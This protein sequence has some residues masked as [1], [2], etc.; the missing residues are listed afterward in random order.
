MINIENLNLGLA[1][2]NQIDWYCDKYRT[3]G[4]SQLT[5]I[6]HLWADNAPIQNWDGSPIGV[7][8]TMPDDIRQNW[9]S[10][11]TIVEDWILES[12]G[13]TRL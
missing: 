1:I 13:A 3:N 9:G 6:I 11:D 5:V 8:L 2:A 4:G 12:I 7:K 10:D